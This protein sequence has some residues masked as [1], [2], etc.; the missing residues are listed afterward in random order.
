MTNANNELEIIN[1]AI[2]S[3]LYVQLKHTSPL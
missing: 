2:Q 3:S 1:K